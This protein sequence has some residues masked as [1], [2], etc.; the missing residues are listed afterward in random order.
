LY[1]NLEN[2][3]SKA[4]KREMYE[5][6]LDIQSLMAE[7]LTSKE[8]CEQL[9]KKWKVAP[10][11]IRHQYEQLVQ[12]LEKEVEEGRA[13]L[14]AKLMARND[15]IYKKSMQEGK[16]KT[17]LDANIA[18]SKLGGL[19]EKAEQAPQRPEMIT[20]KERGKADISLVK[21]AASDE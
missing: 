19:G 6:E 5:R 7:G 21:G 13:E 8:I 2:S 17:A 11:T 15:L 9:G 14:R 20:I 12:A 10:R 16:F 4:S 1:P 18:Q 3:I